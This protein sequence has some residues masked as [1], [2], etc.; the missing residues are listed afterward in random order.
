MTDLL[1]ILLEETNQQLITDQSYNVNKS[2]LF[3]LFKQRESTLEML[4]QKTKED[5]HK[6]FITKKRQFEDSNIP[7]KNNHILEAAKEKYKQTILFGAKEYQTNYNELVKRFEIELEALRDSTLNPRISEK[8]DLSVEHDFK[9]IYDRK[10]A[11]LEAHFNKKWDLFK[12]KVSR[13]KELV[14]AFKSEKIRFD[15]RVRKVK[16]GI[17]KKEEVLS[18]REDTIIRMHAA[19]KQKELSLTIKTEELDRLRTQSI[20]NI[21]IERQ[22]LHDEYTK[23][24]DD[25]ESQRA[26]LDEEFIKVAELRREYT[27]DS[28]NSFKKATFWENFKS[29]SDTLKR[30]MNDER[31][32][33][34]ARQNKEDKIYE[35]EEFF[36]LPLNYSFEDLRKKYK[37]KLQEYHP[38]KHYNKSKDELAKIH[39]LF[40]K[41]QEL[42]NVIKDIFNG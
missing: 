5:A 33:R 13:Y 31:N 7:L 34:L 20:K 40:H 42:Y 6:I 37:I 14:S 22:D 10:N 15:E 41:T 19:L 12:N 17:E 11:Q 25:I 24:M 30:K 36:D 4:W 3:K 38:D 16:L 28:I 1:N 2:K 35:A 8:D 26:K 9:V 23:M 29:T 21:D 39:I 27:S 18:T 32:K